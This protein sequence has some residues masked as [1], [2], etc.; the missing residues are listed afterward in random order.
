MYAWVYDRHWVILVHRRND[1]AARVGA[2]YYYI[3][4][5]LK[6]VYKHKMADTAKTQHVNQVSSIYVCGPSP[7]K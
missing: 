4:W 7:P 2:E 3:M 5:L 1:V 6:G